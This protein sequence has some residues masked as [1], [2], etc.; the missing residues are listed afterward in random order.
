MDIPAMLCAKPARSNWCKQEEVERDLG[1]ERQGISNFFAA[2]RIGPDGKT[3]YK[4]VY[5]QLTA[6]GVYRFLGSKFPTR[7]WWLAFTGKGGT[8]P[9]F[10]ERGDDNSFI[11]EGDGA[12]EVPGAEPRTAV[13]AGGKGGCS[14]GVVREEGDGGAGTAGDEERCVSEL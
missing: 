8:E 4:E 5:S 6:A 14:S 3:K 11:R 13:I 9:I 2:L 1:L 7:V 12:G 10:A